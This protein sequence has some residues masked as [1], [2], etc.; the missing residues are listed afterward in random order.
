VL[1]DVKSMA[2]NIIPAIATTN[3]CVAGMIVVEALKIIRGN[4]DQCRT[5]FIVREPNPRQKLIVDIEP[6]QPNPNCCV[7]SAKPEVY[8]QLNVNTFTIRLLEE[9]LLKHTLNFV[10]PDV[11]IDDNTGTIVISSE[12]GETTALQN[13]TLSELKIGNGCRL[14][15]DDY[16]QHCTLVLIIVHCE[17]VGDESSEFALTT[18]VSELKLLQ[19]PLNE[20]EKPKQPIEDD[21]HDDEIEQIDVDVSIKKRKLPMPVDDDDEQKRKRVS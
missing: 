5:V 12:E 8:V 18:D 2:G 10:A 1:F 21:D 6:Y 13:K 17:R 11:E 4:M 14:R 20:S 3:A 19:T 9:K 15:C 7:C 16:M